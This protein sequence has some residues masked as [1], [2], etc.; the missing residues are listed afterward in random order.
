MKDSKVTSESTG[1]GEATDGELFALMT[2]KGDEGKEAWAV[3]YTR[4]VSDLCRL[5]CR[6]RGL[7]NGGVDELVQDAMVQAYKAAHTFRA[8]DSLD[9]EAS[10]R[11]TLA[12]LG[13]MARN[14]YWSMLRRQ[15]GVTV[16][17]LPGQEED[18]SRLSAKGRPLAAG[19]LYREVQATEDRVA[20][21]TAVDA[22]SLRRRL[23][24]EALDALP[25]RERD[26]IIETYEYYERGQK[27]QRLPKQVVDKIC[28]THG[29]R[30]D[31]L[32]QLRKR[33]QEKIEEYVNARM[34][35]ES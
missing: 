16:G 30:P 15:K 14:L 26:I 25:E 18:G 20:G 33:A 28:R 34:P 32:R 22:P 11:R 12:W 21:V 31:H 6:V 3:F 1:M 7:P 17:S 4:Y 9:G 23:L 19:E 2:R 29:I 10:R 35:A 8:D 5:V 27:Q 24:R 13:R